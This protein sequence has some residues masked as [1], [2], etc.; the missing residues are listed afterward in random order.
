VVIDMAE[1][2]PAM[3]ATL[4][5]TGRR[6]AFDVLVRNPAAI[7]RVERWTLPRVSHVLVVVEESRDRLTALGVPAERITLVS[8]TPPR[9]RADRAEPS[10]RAT[11]SPLR[12]VYL[13]LLEIHRG[14]GE[15]LAAAAMLRD[16]GQP[17][18]VTIIGDGRDDVI[19]HQQALELGLGP[20]MVTF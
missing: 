20:P 2:Y 19:F 12:L 7:A 9:A 16:R 3:I 1:N 17:V 15:L 11:G 13:G 6:R 14:V 18:S 4:W 5:E 8:N 10:R